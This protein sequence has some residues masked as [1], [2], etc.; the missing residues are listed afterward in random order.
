MQEKIAYRQMSIEEK[1][2]LVKEKDAAKVKKKNIVKNPIIEDTE[3]INEDQ[4]ETK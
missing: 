4:E 1:I 3:I 2:Q